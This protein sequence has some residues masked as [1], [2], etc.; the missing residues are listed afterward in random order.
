[1]EKPRQTVSEQ[2]PA[3][4]ARRGAKLAL[5][6]VLTAA[7]LAA[8]VHAFGGARPFFAAL[9][10]ARAGWVG[11]AFAAALG[12]VLLAAVRWGLVLSAMGYNLG[13][14]RTLSVV[15]SAWPLVVVTPSRT[16]EFLRA[17][18][19]RKQVPLASGAGSV[20]AEKAVDV[21]VLLAL[22]CAGAVLHGFWLLGAFMGL[23]MLLELGVVWAVMKNRQRLGR[24]PLFRTHMQRIEQL[25]SAF[26][27]LGRAP[28]KLAALGVVSLSIR[29]FAVAVTYALLVAVG[30]HVGWLDTLTLWPVATLVGLIP[31]TVA[32]MG[33]R[34]GAFIY[35]LRA[36]GVALDKPAV[37]AATMGYSVVA[38]WTFA[39]IGLPFMLREAAFRGAAR[40]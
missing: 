11:A 16:N 18:A 13:Y 33:T 20:L 9:A 15:L 37:L 21:F 10:G 25:F 23:G 27:A 30:A 6:G 3:L 7:L 36:G 19:V 12:C 5:F 8:L 31:V 38:V 28:Q 24:L 26:G 40:A 34:D 39:L 17:L 2:A 32:G 22:A 35:L 1:L 29:V 4:A 14:R